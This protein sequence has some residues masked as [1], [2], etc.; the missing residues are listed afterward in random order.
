MEFLWLDWDEDREEARLI[1]EDGA[2]REWDCFEDEDDLCARGRRL[3][4]R[5]RGMGWILIE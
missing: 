1:R 3:A 2:E 5:A 4:E